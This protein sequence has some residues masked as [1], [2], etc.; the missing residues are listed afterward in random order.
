MGVGG[1]ERVCVSLANEFEELGHEVHIVVLNLDNDVNTQLLNKGVQVHELG[2]SRIRYSP[3]PMFKFIK[4]EKPES[5]LVFGNEMGI[6]LNKMRSLHLFKLKLVVRVLNNVNISF[7]KD[8]KVPKVVEKYLKSQQKQLADM[9]AVVAQCG[10]MKEMLLERKLVKDSQVHAIYNPVSA[11]VVDA[12]SKTERSHKDSFRFTFI[13]RIDPQKNVK[14]LLEV[15]SDVVRRRP[16]AKLHIIGDGLQMDKMKALKDELNLN[17]SVVFEGLRKDMEQVYADSDA[18][19]LTSNYEGMPNCLIEAIAC[20]IPVISYDCPIGPKE[21][22]V[23]GTNGFLVPF[24]DKEIMA[25]KMIEAMDKEWNKEEIRKT[26][27]KFNV[28][29][30]APKY[31]ELLK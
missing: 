14:D 1:A 17:E 24:L 16:E 13:G 11:K 29:S 26:A 8:D 27:D 10:A 25:K 19:V 9:E 30:I 4:R 18:V 3:L 20:G 21:I 28:K 7:E 2:V 6:I 15:F 23:D 22:V 5:M 31:I 12:A